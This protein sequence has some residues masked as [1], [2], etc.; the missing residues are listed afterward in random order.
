MPKPTVLIQQ[1]SISHY[2]LKLFELLCKN[3]DFNISILADNRSETPYLKTV[4]QEGNLGLRW[5]KVKTYA[6]RIPLLRTLYW[7]A[8]S[9]SAVISYKPNAVIA[10]GSPYSLTA[11][12]I[13]FI[14]K[15]RKVP[16]LLWTHG[17]LEDEKGIK[18]FIR[19][20]F[21]KIADK[22]L[23]YGQHAKYILKNK[24]F[25]ENRISVV[26]NSLD[27]DLQKKIVSTLCDHDREG[28]KN[29]IGVIAGEGLVAF[30]GRLQAVKQIDL[31]IKAIAILTK[32][33]RRVHAAIIGDGSERKKLSLLAKELEINELIHFHG[34]S[35][36]ER[37]IGTVFSSSS[38]CV[39]PSGAGLTVMHAMAYG[40]P[41]LIH[42]RIEFHFPEWEA[43]RENETGFFYQY[44]NVND[45]AEKI[46]MAVF[47]SYDKEKIRH[48]CKEIIENNYNPYKQCDSI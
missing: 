11:W 35:Y 16:V 36:N 22:L 26:Y 10:M 7:Q 3:D 24:R 20:F 5:I 4:Y 14:C 9:L 31:L 29:R 12:A 1:N 19:R 17:L 2:R 44:G 23:L 28:Y 33:G 48:N 47:G 46:N 27:Y 40:T 8:G 45:M 25:Q 41:V 18:W 39:I 15:I 30:S 37:F 6:I 38:L 43:V 34:E 32:K 13:C 42:D 21:Y